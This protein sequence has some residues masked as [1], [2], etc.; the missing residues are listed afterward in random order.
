MQTMDER[1]ELGEWN[2]RNWI[3]YTRE[4][5]E[6][7]ASPV[8][9][10][11]CGSA[12]FAGVCFSERKAGKPPFHECNSRQGIFPVGCFHFLMFRFMLAGF[13]LSTEKEG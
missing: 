7:P 1:E 6:P 8:I 9:F 13:H 4:L 10:G 12:Q 11:S 3:V 2:G 5:K